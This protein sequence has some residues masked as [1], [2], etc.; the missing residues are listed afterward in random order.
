MGA[1]K[2]SVETVLA[3]NPE[4]TVMDLA[5]EAV[6]DHSEREGCVFEDNAAARA[7]GILGLDPAIRAGDLPH[8]DIVQ[9]GDTLEE[10]EISCAH[11]TGK[12]DA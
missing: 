3:Q 7:V 1:A 8:D 2:I 10:L 4:I 12:A 11:K 5:S 6:K 9:L